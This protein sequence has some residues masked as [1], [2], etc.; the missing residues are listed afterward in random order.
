MM[1][2]ELS[3][4]GPD[5]HECCSEH[6]VCVNM[7]SS[8]LATKSTNRQANN[9]AGKKLASWKTADKNHKRSRSGEASSQPCKRAEE[10]SVEYLMEGGCHSDRA[11]RHLRLLKAN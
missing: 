10:A 6:H 1:A 2:A 5:A 7:T 4:H 3:I 8:R 9:V 11:A